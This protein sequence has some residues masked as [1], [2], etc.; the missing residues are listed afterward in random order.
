MSVKVDNVLEQAARAGLLADEV[1]AARAALPENKRES[2]EEVLA[3]LVRRGKLTRFQAGHILKGRAK[4]LVLGSYVL[5]EPLGQGG[6][7]MVFRARHTMMERIAAVKMLPSALYKDEQNVKRFLREVK[8]AAKLVHPNI[9]QAYDA[10]SDNGRYFLA[11]ELVDGKTLDKIVKERGRLPVSM[12]VDYMIQAGQ[13]LAYAHQ[14]NVIHRDIKPANLILGPKNRVQILD[15]GLARMTDHPGKSVQLTSVDTSMGTIDFMAPE[16]ALELK[17]ADARSDVYSLGC[18]LYF[19]IRGDVMF[20]GAPSTQRMMAHQQQCPP[21]LC[22]GRADVPMKLDAVYQRMVAKRP[23]DRYPN[24]ADAISDLQQCLTAKPEMVLLQ[25]PAPAA[26]NEAALHATRRTQVTRR[27]SRPKRSKSRIHPVALGLAIGAV[28]VVPVMIGLLVWAFSGKSDKGADS[29]SAYAQQAA[30]RRPFNPAPATAATKFGP[31][32]TVLLYDFL[33]ANGGGLVNRE[34]QLSDKNSS[35]YAFHLFARSSR[36]TDEQIH[37]EVTADQNLAG[38]DGKPGVLRFQMHEVPQDLTFLGFSFL[39]RGAGGDFNVAHWR[40]GA[41]GRTELQ[42]MTLSFRYKAPRQL[43]LNCRVEPMDNSFHNRLDLG[44]FS[45][46]MQW[47]TFSKRFSDGANV[48]RFLSTVNGS[49]GQGVKLKVTFANAGTDFH[50]GDSL[51]IDDIKLERQPALAGASGSP[52]PTAPALASAK[53]AEK[54]YDFG[55]A[56]GGGW[57]LEG[58]AFTPTGT[59]KYRLGLFGKL[60]DGAA[61]QVRLAAV[62]DGDDV[63]A[64]G[65]NGVLSLQILECPR[66]LLFAGFEFHGRVTETGLKPPEF[67]PGRLATAD[68]GQWNLSFQHRVIRAP[69]AQGKALRFGCAWQPKAADA[70]SAALKFPE[71][72]STGDWRSFSGSFA[73]AKDVEAFLNVVNRLGIENCSL[74]WSLSPEQ[75]YAAGDVLLID[76]VKISYTPSR[77]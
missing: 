67:R 19:L 3:E 6:M 46:G 31:A 16:Q 62:E 65:K 37:L 56:R 12:A 71:F 4:A 20:A 59:P 39:G 51:L 15:M 18:T 61:G 28:I 40:P 54:H 53:E 13:G 64:D 48:E 35:A 34:G 7:G 60:K 14:H 21:S 76:D 27:Y 26:N 50:A 44:D 32:S 77:A 69:E 23:A 74:V 36:G 2:S 41:I 42:E 11:M 38:P 45:A 47:A 1:A 75:T 63:G 9:V 29:A 22:E 72:E 8:A 70:Y 30:A 49:G 24:V 17:K 73:S 10:G 25:P 52:A 5:E 55:D 66:P 68:L 43:R 33:D 57:L 58:E